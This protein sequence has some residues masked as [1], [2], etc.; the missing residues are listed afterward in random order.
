MPTILARNENVNEV[1]NYP[2]QVDGNQPHCNE[3]RS[4]NKHGLLVA[5][6]IEWK[7]WQP[8]SEYIKHVLIKNT[9]LKIQKITYE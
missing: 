4:A 7:N 8:G 5:S 1:S 3:S 6:R 9:Q 2:L